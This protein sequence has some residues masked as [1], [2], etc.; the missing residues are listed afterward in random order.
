MRKNLTAEERRTVTIDAV[1]DL[2]AEQDP[3]NITTAAI[4]SH[5]NLTQGALFRHFPNKE[6]IW[7]A[8]MEWVSNRLL[9]R[10]T[11]AAANAD[12][13]LVALESVF[14][15]HVDFIASHP[16]VPR[17]LFGELQRAETTPAKKIVHLMLKKY[18]LLI[19]SLIE[20]GKTQ[21]IVAIDIDA[22]A[23]SIM[24]I[25]SIQGLVMQ[26]MLSGDVNLIKDNAEGIFNLFSRSI[27]KKL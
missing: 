3:S 6:A 20:E 17:M 18:G 13:P 23:A 16:G 21:N 10:V 19:S 26:S 14:M 25:G 27:E 24:F 4:A 12:N 15:T 5:M 2:A 1:I 9:S 7:Q 11:K 22:T 8:V